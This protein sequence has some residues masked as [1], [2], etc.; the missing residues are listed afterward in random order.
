MKLLNRV[1]LPQLLLNKS[2]HTKQLA[3]LQNQVIVLLPH[4]TKS[5]LIKKRG[6]KVKKMVDEIEEANVDTSDADKPVAKK[7]VQKA[8]KATD[9]SDSEKPTD[10]NEN[11]AQSVGKKHRAK[12][13]DATTA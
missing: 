8:K 3:K 10:V 7:P 4:L 9:H 11:L 13:T 1:T 2:Q 12:K 6:P 5:H